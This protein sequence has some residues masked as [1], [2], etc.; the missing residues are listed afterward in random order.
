MRARCAVHFAEVRAA[1]AENVKKKE[2]LIAEAE[3][4]AESTDWART[5]ERLRAMQGEWRATG[6]V[7]RAKSDELWA[8]FRA[9]GGRFF[10]RQK[11]DRTRRRAERAK[12]LERKQAL[13]AEAEALADSTDWDRAAAEIKRLQI[14][15]AGDG[16]GG[17]GQG[18]GAVAAVP[19][20]RRPLLR[21]LQEPRGPG[22]GGPRRRARGDVRRARGPGRGRGAGEDL[23]DRVRAAQAAWKA[24]P[25][26]SGPRAA[27]SRRGTPPRWR[28]VVDARP[29]AFKGTDLDTAANR[30]RLEALCATVEAMAKDDAKPA[31]AAASPA[32]VLAERWREAL[33]ANTMGAKVDESARQARAQGQGRSGA[34]GVVAGRSGRIVG[35]G[36]AER[37]V[38]RR[39]PARAGRE[40]AKG[41]RCR[42]PR[43]GL[44]VHAGGEAEG[45]RLVGQVADARARPALLVEGQQRPLVGQVVARRAPR[46][47]CRA[48]GRA[49]RLTMS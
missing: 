40:L 7:T 28:R 19:P 5:A 17:E 38:P 1:R 20:G 46:P 30:A 32:A 6:P 18:G 10:A 8:R 27:R 47:T 2:A 11:E 15:M 44:V 22:G 16:V 4:L 14:G 37:A 26:L 9:A 24:A 35:P 3:A 34:R 13:C 49:R 25:A 39:L 48:A 29:D 42:A 31:A 12:N 33:A 23:A 41:A 45:P 36:A 21:A 43:G